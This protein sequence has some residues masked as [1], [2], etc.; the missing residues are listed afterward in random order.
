MTRFSSGRLLS[1][2]IRLHGI[3]LGRPVDLI[4]RPET[5]QLLG[6]EIR[7]GDDTHRFLPFA[8]ARI[9]EHEIAIG[10][11][12]L[13][14]DELPFYRRRGRSFGGLRGARVRA[15]GVAAGTLKD[16][17]VGEDGKIE[18]LLVAGPTGV[19]EVPAGG[20]VDIEEPRAPAA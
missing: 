12:L 16:V 5:M 1:L 9:G 17:L 6:L 13:L 20:G 14:L 10:S 8:A 19:R 4:L 2:P 3:E 18:R 7:C 15:G 11:A